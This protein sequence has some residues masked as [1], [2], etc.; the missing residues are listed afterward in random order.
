MLLE[1]HR[2]EFCL[3]ALPSFGVRLRFHPLRRKSLGVS[4]EAL[5]AGGDGWLRSE[6]VFAGLAFKVSL[7]FRRLV[8]R[9]AVGILVLL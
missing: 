2:C 3:Y 5:G 8:S 9:I 4:V 1:V 7:A 6:G